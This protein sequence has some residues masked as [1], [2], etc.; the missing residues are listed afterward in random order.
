MNRF[1]KVGVLLGGISDERDVSLRSGEAVGAGLQEAG[2][3]VDLIDVREAAVEVAPDVEAVFNALHG[4]FGEDGGLQEVLET[5][6]VPYTG[7]GPVSSRLS[8]DKILSKEVMEDHGLPTPRWLALDRCQRPGDC[9]SVAAAPEWGLPSVIKPSG[10][11]S[12]I[13]VMC[14]EKMEEWPLALE[15]AF[16]YGERV[17]VEQYIPGRELTVGIVD[18]EVLPVV[19]IIPGAGS[20][21]YEA[22]YTAGKTQYEV[23]A[24]LDADV[25]ERCRSLALRLYD[26]LSCSSLGRVDFRLDRDGELYILELNSIPGFTQTSLLPKAAACAGYHFA[27]LCR[28]IM[29]TASLKP[30]R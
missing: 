1:K 13:G 21:D 3:R 29:E 6:K 24:A 10:Q 11:G 28:K 5:M 27:S 25:A 17:L 9:A 8:F 20:Y 23:P 18:G 30:E 4:T 2:Y 7:S 15:R 16:T 14:V 12:S 22:K 26:A 19:E